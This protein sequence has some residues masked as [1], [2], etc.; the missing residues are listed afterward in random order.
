MISPAGH[1]HA[2]HTQKA[3]LL[4][5]Q[6]CSGTTAGHGTAESVASGTF[7]HTDRKNRSKSESF[8]MTC[9]VRRK[10]WFSFETK[11]TKIRV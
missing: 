7:C 9:C 4:M 5:A 11:P 2:P 3:Q 6:P 8:C 10:V 1:G